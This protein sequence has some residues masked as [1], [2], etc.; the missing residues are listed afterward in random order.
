[1]RNNINRYRK[2]EITQL[3][4]HGVVYYRLRIFDWEKPEEVVYETTRMSVEGAR[5]ALLA[6]IYRG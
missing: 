2:P 5:S 4:K 6:W 1:M 3:C